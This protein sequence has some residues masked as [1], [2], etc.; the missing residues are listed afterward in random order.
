MTFQHTQKKNTGQRQLLAPQVQQ[1][2]LRL[3]RPQLLR[4]Q[5]SS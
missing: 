4:Q 1:Q 5:T 2:L 3:R